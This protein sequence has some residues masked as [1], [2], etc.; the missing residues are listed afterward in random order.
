MNSGLIRLSSVSGSSERIDQPIAS[1]SSIVRS[2]S[3]RWLTNSFS[4]R[5]ATF[6]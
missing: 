2:S 4:K 3:G 6:R 1:D 5:S